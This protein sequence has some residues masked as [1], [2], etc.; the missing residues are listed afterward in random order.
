MIKF[1]LGKFYYNKTAKYLV[2]IL[3]SF[4]NPF[5]V[6]YKKARKSLVCTAIGDILYDVAKRKTHK[7]CLF[8]V[9]NINGEYKDNEYID[10]HKS[11]QD[12]NSYIEY[13]RTRHFYLDDYIFVV[14]KYHCVVLSIPDVYK[15]S[16]DFFLNSQY[17]LMYDNHQLQECLIKSTSNASN[18]Y[19]VLT[20][21]PEY[22]K[23][24]EQKL[25]EYFNTSIAIDDDREFDLPVK[26]DNEI[27]NYDGRKI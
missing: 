1:K 7:Y 18:I 3:N 14:N 24:F 4:D 9:Y 6:Q 10:I 26:L 2:P 22:K 20:K 27:L 8:F 5:K 16:L 25:N 13:V 11:R 17:S 19:S 21:Q 23:I 15:D 12:L